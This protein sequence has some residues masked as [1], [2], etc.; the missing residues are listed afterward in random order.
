[1]ATVKLIGLAL[2]GVTGLFKGSMYMH[3]LGAIIG[4]ALAFILFYIY[5]QVIDTYPPL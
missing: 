5:F 3:K 4:L 2:Y 1:M